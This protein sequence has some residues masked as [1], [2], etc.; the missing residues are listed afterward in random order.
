[1]NVVIGLGREVLR[2]LEKDLTSENLHEL[3]DVE[4]KG[5]TEQLWHWHDAAM[6]ELIKRGHV[7]SRKK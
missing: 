5:L 2:Q 3:N 1:L 7:V 6:R 4:L